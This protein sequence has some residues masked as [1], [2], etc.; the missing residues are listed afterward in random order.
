MSPVGVGSWAILFGLILVKNKGGY[1]VL[2][3]QSN[4]SLGSMTT[5][6]QTCLRMRAVHQ[7]RVTI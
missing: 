4:N 7:P 2:S 5:Q 3:E 6:S 1:K